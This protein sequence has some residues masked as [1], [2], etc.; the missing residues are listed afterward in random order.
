MISIPRRG[1]GACLYGLQVSG[2]VSREKVIPIGHV[3][4]ICVVGSDLSM[5]LQYKSRL[6]F[7]AHVS[8]PRE[9]IVPKRFSCTTCLFE[10]RV[11]KATMVFPKC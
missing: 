3:V 9:R 10:R 5:G 1:T 2:R 11:D 6:G 8:A 4:L 7:C